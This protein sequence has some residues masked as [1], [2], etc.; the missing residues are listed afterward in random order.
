MLQRGYRVP[1]VDFAPDLVRRHEGHGYAVRC[2]DAEDPE[3]L[4]TLP[5]GQVPRVLS[6][7]REMPVNVALLHGLRDHSYSGQMAVT[8]H[9]FRNAEQLEG[10]GADYVLMPYAD[11]AAEAV[12]RLFGQD[13]QTALV[14]IPAVETKG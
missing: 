3:F 12:N 5:L 6:S 1:G 14:S 7:V 2:G 13:R 10:A 11:T 9:S 4:A 8:A